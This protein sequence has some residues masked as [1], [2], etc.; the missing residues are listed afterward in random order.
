MTTASSSQGNITLTPRYGVSSGGVA[1]DASAATA[2]VAS[3]SNV[4]WFLAYMFV[5]RSIGLAGANSTALGGGFFMTTVAAIAAS[6]G[7][8]V[9]FGSTGAKS[10]DASISSGLYMG[11]T[12]GNAS[13]TMTTRFVGL[14]SLN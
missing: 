5:M 8:V 7:N 10:V 1:L 12:L 4:P 3:A 14:T 11:V 2:L 13:D 6:T 9:P